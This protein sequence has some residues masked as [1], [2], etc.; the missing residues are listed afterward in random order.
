MKTRIKIVS[1]LIILAIT[2]TSLSS[3]AFAVWIPQQDTAAITGEID[4]QGEI[5]TAPAPYILD[6]EN[7]L[8]LPLRAVAEQLGYVVVW[9][10]YEQRII[11]GY[12]IQVWI[13]RSYYVV[14]RGAQLELS[15][16]V[17][18]T[19]GHTF[20]PEDFI[21]YALGYEVSV[22]TGRVIIGENLTS[23]IWVAT[24][25]VSVWFSDE[26]PYERPEPMETISVGVA[27]GSH[28]VFALLRLPLGANW[29]A[30]EVNQA[31]LFLKLDEGEPQSEIYVGTVSQVWSYN[32][33]RGRARYIVYEESFALTEIIREAD[34]WVS[35]DVTDIVVGWL[36]GDIANRGFALFPGAEYTIASFVTGLRSPIMYAPRIVI[37]AEL[38]ERA[39][40]F[41]RFG[42]TKQPGQGTAD[43]MLGGNCFSFALRDLDGIYYEH[44][45]FDFDEINRVFFEYGVNGVLEH[46][47]GV[48]TNYVETH[49]EALAIS[50]FRRIESFDSP[51]NPSVEYRI[52][53][54][55]AAEATELLPMSER[56]G[57]DFHFWVQLNDGRWAQT[58][59]AMF[60]AIVPGTGPGIDPVRFPWDG[61]EQW[62][63]ERFQEVYA[64]DAV[65]FAVTK[66]I[67]EFTRH[68]Q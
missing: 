12:G 48:L 41:G 36:S 64:S 26:S 15:A 46:V 24:D 67:D 49:S 58:N 22:Y 61:S 39:Y 18:L 27:P 30:H 66:D 62:G 3:L 4:V 25:V 31:R 10:D 47:A 68:R 54:R 57:F 17:E 42:F 50:N 34:G 7:V 45:N 37:C 28:D 59:P 29:L 32:T 21:R 19:G 53:M 43:P 14:G 5:I 60:S 23:T 51:I 52:A 56:G 38:S 2:F 9:E 6:T 40:D 20:V 11:V 13:G 55:V 16:P 35:L 1:S 65:F 33:E 44:L 63:F 8:M